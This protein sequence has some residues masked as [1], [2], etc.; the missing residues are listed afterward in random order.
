MSEEKINYD[1]DQKYKKLHSIIPIK[2]RFA[3]TLVKPSKHRGTKRYA[4]GRQKGR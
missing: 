1:K 3:W 2:G 4:D